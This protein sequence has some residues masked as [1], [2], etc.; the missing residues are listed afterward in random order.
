MNENFLYLCIVL[1]VIFHFIVAYEFYLTR[2]RGTGD[3][4]VYLASFLILTI[5]VCIVVLYLSGCKEL[6]R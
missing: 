5:D 3:K 6:F 2:F 1:Y 4:N